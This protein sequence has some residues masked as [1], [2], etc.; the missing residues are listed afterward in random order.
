MREPSWEGVGG[1]WTGGEGVTAY[2]CSIIT[3]TLAHTHRGCGDP[4]RQLLEG[5]EVLVRLGG[6]A[7]R[8]QVAPVGRKSLFCFQGSQLD[9]CALIEET[10]GRF[11][12]EG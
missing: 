2:F 4:G 9:V 8:L 6:C 7:P 3:S 12:G 10:R 5:P 1:W 11:R